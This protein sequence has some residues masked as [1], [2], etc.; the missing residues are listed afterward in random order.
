VFGDAIPSFEATV[1]GWIAGNTPSVSA[2]HA[3]RQ[4]RNG[5]DQLSLRELDGFA[6]P[7]W[8]LTPDGQLHGIDLTPEEYAAGLAEDVGVAPPVFGEARQSLDEK[9]ADWGEL[10]DALL[11]AWLERDTTVTVVDVHA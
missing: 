7:G 3:G 9:T 4:V 6:V 5:V 8:V 1:L 2:G 10:V 11:A